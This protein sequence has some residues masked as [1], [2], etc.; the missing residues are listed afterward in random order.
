MTR[1]IIFLLIILV[2]AGSQNVHAG[3]G[4][5]HFVETAVEMEFQN[6]FVAALNFP[7]TRDVFPHLAEQLPPV[8]PE[9]ATDG[10]R[11]R[12]RAS[13]SKALTEKAP[14]HS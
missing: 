8:V 4:E 6:E 5:I 11:A 13:R 1:K 12:R 9:P 2:S 10:R 14:E 7:H 3:K